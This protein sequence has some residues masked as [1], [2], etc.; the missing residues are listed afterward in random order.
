MKK[1]I[2]FKIMSQKYLGLNLTKEMKDVYVY[3]K[4]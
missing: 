4:L 1:T 2:L 3:W